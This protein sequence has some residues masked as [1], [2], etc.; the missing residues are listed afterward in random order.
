MSIVGVDYLSA[1]I[2][3]VPDYMTALKEEHKLLRMHYDGIGTDE[4]IKQITGLESQDQ[5][6][7]RKKYAR[8]NKNIFANITNPV[9]KIFAAKGKY[10]SYDLPTDNDQKK[11]TSYINTVDHGKSLENWLSSYW[12]DKIASDPNGV[13]FVEK[14]KEGNPYP[15]YKSILSIR[16]YKQRGQ[17]L[18]YII[19]EP[20]KRQIG[21][22]E[23]EFVRV[24]DDEADKLFK[25]T[26]DGIV[27]LEDER[28]VNEL[29]YVPGCV[30][31][32]LENTNTEFK[33][34]SIWNEV[35][36]ANEYFRDNSVKSIYKLTNGY[37]IFWMY[38]S[39]CPVCKG[40]GER[41]G[42]KCNYCNGS[43]LALKKDVSEIIGIKPPQT[44]DDIT[45]TPDIAG[46]IS[47]PPENLEQMTSE[48]SLL[49]D[50][51]L[52]SH[53]GSSMETG[54]NNTAT[55]KWID[56]QPVYDKLDNYA[57]NLETIETLLV[58]F[59]GDILY[60]ESYKGSTINYGRRF[61]VETPDQL[62]DKYIKGKEKKLNSTTLDYLLGLYY[63][64]QFNTSPV[65]LEYHLKLM[66]LEPLVHYNL[67]E[68]PQDFRNTFEYQKKLYLEEWINTVKQNDI[69]T[70]T[71]QQLDK[72]LTK[73][74][75]N[76]ITENESKR[77]STET[78][79]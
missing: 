2:G 39:Q 11:F 54:D 76:K 37:P 33:K 70:K 71:I 64:T 12:K 66:Q 72:D 32:T 19:F 26:N 13:F 41:E 73:F 50:M 28:I 14:D 35:E 29:G 3:N 1:V 62:L 15:T 40:V 5:L 7:L 46:Y 38:Y 63:Q 60:K 59:I 74:T 16:D 78:V 36:L 10:K 4:Y 20:Y 22:S 21:T 51:M 56:V 23:I 48:L 55:G 61:L 68:V 44:A 24:V 52:F 31:S 42:E 47:P 69:I 6:K 18:E 65:M 49:K 57:A 79:Q 67:N 77:Q 34:S 25:V 17:Y 75:E 53:W 8:S 45:I 58:D 30:I 27:E 9:N 43:G